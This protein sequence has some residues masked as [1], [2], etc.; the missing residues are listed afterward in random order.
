VLSSP[1]GIPE[2]RGLTGPIAATRYYR[3]T[4]YAF[5]VGGVTI[6][7]A[8]LMVHLVAPLDATGIGVAFAMGALLVTRG[9]WR[10]RGAAKSHPESVVYQTLHS[11]PPQLQEAWLRRWIPLGAV[12]FVVMSAMTAKDLLELERGQVDSARMWAL[13]ASRTEDCR[14]PARR[15]NAR[16]PTTRPRQLARRTLEAVPEVTVWPCPD[17]VDGVLTLL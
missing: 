3:R 1:E 4:G 2:S 15:R 14:V 5:I 11:A 13:I 12:A 7:V 9:V 6:V 16:A 8:V 17:R 10:L